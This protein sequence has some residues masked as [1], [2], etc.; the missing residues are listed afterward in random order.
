MPIS[1]I[2]LLALTSFFAIRWVESRNEVA[3]LKTEASRLEALEA[4]FSNGDF[5]IENSGDSAFSIISIDVWYLNDSLEITRYKKEG[6]DERVEPR[7]SI[8][9]EE[10]DG[11]NLQYGSKVL[12]YEIGVRLDEISSDIWFAWPGFH[13]KAESIKL[14]PYPAYW[15]MVGQ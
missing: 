13:N 12:F 11:T 15:R 1:M 3:A 7:R 6:L 14:N 2:L 8:E 9:F 4:I 5:V 10:W